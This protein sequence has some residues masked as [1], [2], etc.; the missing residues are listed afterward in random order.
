MKNERGLIPGI[1]DV[2]RAERYVALYA[3]NALS[4]GEDFCDIMREDG[5]DLLA[6]Y[7]EKLRDLYFPEDGAFFNL[8]GRY[9]YDSIP[10]QYSESPLSPSAIKLAERLMRKADVS[11]GILLFYDGMDD[12]QKGTVER[13]CQKLQYTDEALRTQAIVASH[14]IILPFF[15]QVKF[16]VAGGKRRYKKMT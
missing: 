2:R 5:Q 4:Y 3:G 15:I 7:F 6:G 14:A 1:D 12:L 16:G 13:L 9:T 8:G 11:K 10:G